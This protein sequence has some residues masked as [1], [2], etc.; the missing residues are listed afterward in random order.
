MKYIV[1]GISMLLFT[2]IAQGQTVDVKDNKILV[3]GKEFAMIEEL[4]CGFWDPGCTYYIRNSKG[5]TLII[6]VRR[7]FENTFYLRFSFSGGKGIAET[8]F[9]ALNPKVKDIAQMIVKT[10]LIKDDELNEDEIQNFVQAHGTFYSD[11]AK[12]LNRQN[13]NKQKEKEKEKQ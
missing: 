3:D 2:A 12:S 13:K 1:I 6:I 9:P 10:N 11:I 4:G 7:S 5:K 8:P